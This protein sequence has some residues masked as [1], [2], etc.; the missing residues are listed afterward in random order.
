MACWP[1]S[2][3]VDQPCLLNRDPF[4]GANRTGLEPA[5]AADY[6]ALSLITCSS[7]KVSRARKT[8][9]NLGFPRVVPEED[10]HHQHESFL[11][12]SIETGC[13]V[14]RSSARALQPGGPPLFS[15]T[16]LPPF[17]CDNSR[18]QSFCDPGHYEVAA[19]VMEGLTAS[20]TLLD[21]LG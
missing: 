17:A 18:Q 2:R 8:P 1:D 10:E 21:I 15:F 11:L 7:G 13:G 14:Y 20:W 4:Q 16:R 19:R 6:A 12:G 5:L 3:P 9:Q